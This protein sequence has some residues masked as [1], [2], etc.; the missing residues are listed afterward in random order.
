MRPS[1]PSCAVPRGTTASSSAS[2]HRTTPTRRRRP[3]R[4]HPPQ[5]PLR[6]R[7]GRRRRQPAPVRRAWGRAVRRV[8]GTA[9]GG[10]RRRRRAAECGEHAANL[11]G[12]FQRPLRG[13]VGDAG[14]CRA[15]RHVPGHGAREPVRGDWRNDYVRFVDLLVH[16][17]IIHW[18]AHE[19]WGDRDSHL[20][21]FTG[22]AA[23]DDLERGGLVRRPARCGSRS[24]VLEQWPQPP[25]RL[26]EARERLRRLLD[27]A[28]RR[29]RPAGGDIGDLTDSTLS[30]FPPFPSFS[31]ETVPTGE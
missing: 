3:T 27:A 30:P 9:S 22:P 18:H 2:T 26:V 11:A 8:A 19:N 20:T 14:G 1:G 21:L 17:P 12:R 16:V 23:R 4:C 6:R 29:N 13:A 5:H 7:R 31:P 24:V 10:G 28:A 15:G 25:E